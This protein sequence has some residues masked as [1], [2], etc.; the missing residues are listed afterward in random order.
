MVCAV[1]GP[2]A[3]FYSTSNSINYYNGELA[4]FDD[5]EGSIVSYLWSF[6]DASPN[7]NEQN[8]IHYYPIGTPGSFNVGLTV[9]DTNGCQD[10]TYLN[11]DLIEDFSVYVPNT[12]TLDGDGLNEGF[13]PVFSNVD[14]LKG[15]EIQ[16][17]NRW[18]QLVWQSEQPAEAWY[19]R[20]K[21]NKDVQLGTYTW[22]IKYTDN[23]TVT[24]TI[25][26]TV[27][28]IR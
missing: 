20:Y 25:V 15:Y 17:F 19:G 27:N 4:L 3:A 22:K 13:L 28:V 8:P 5:S 9:T 1:D 2:T 7:S 21:D 24:R 26:G 14:L 11:F 18:G 6:G 12:I 16:I 23:L 10:T